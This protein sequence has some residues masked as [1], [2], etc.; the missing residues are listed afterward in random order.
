M[1]AADVSHAQ[2]KRFNTTGRMMAVWRGIARERGL[3][4]EPFQN[5]FLF[6]I[7]SVPCPQ[8][9]V[10]TLRSHVCGGGE[11]GKMVKWWVR[12]VLKIVCLVIGSYTSFLL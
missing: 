4:L 3:L 10:F 5:A 11:N 9:P 8:S 12:L 6:Y 1:A 2:S 7:L